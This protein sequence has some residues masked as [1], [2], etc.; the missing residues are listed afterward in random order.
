[1]RPHAHITTR[2]GDVMDLSPDMSE[3]LLGS[4]PP[5]VLERIRADLGV[6]AVDVQVHI[7][8]RASRHKDTER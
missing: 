1:M 2:D 6:H 4:I 3:A 8:P 7:V 5:E